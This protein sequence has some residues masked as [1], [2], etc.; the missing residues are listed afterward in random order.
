MNVKANER[1][2]EQE[3]NN[4]IALQ[5]QANFKVKEKEDNRV[6]ADIQSENDN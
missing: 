1:T 2:S 4:D 6:N 3:R 5:Q